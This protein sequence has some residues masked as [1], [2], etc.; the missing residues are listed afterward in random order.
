MNKYTLPIACLL[1]LLTCEVVRAHLS[2]TLQHS[3]SQDEEASRWALETS[4]TFPMVRIYM[5][6]MS[7]AQSERTE[8][9]IGFAFQNWKNTD[10]KPLGQSHAF[11][12]LM[13]Y[14]HYFWRNLHFEIEL[15]PAWN[16]FESAFDG[17][18]YRGFELWSE[19]KI[20][21]RFDLGTRFYAVLQPG[22]GHG[23]WIQN[24]WPDVDF[25]NYWEFVRDSVIFV[26]QVLVAVRL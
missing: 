16:R 3:E 12:L 2:G 22:M 11:T 21:Y 4:L 14:R 1:M 8:L 13:S 17:K 24:P 6:K 15:W 18:T 9:G 10:Q 7:Y 23:V 19:Y 25:N 26:P 5:A 20:G